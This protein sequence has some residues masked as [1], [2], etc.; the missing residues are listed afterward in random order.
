[1]EPHEVA[2]LKVL[3]GVGVQPPAARKGGLVWAPFAVA[4]RRVFMLN[5]LAPSQPF[6]RVFAWRAELTQ[7]SG[8]R[9]GCS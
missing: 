7:I 6:D 3:L 2:L 5:A 4:R 9:Q 1:M 8:A